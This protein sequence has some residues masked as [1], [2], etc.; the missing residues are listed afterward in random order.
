M[1]ALYRKPFTLPSLTLVLLLPA[2]DGRPPPPRAAWSVPNA[3]LEALQDAEALKFSIEEHD[4]N[5]QRID[6]LLGR[7]QTPVR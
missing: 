2:C 3:H 4:K 5:R 6:E 1:D 7:D